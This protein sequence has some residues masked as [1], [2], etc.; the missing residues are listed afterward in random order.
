MELSLLLVILHMISSI[1]QSTLQ[2]ARRRLRGCKCTTAMKRLQ[3]REV[4]AL[5]AA[6]LVCCQIKRNVV[7]LPANSATAYGA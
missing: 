7:L 4:F 5:P 6:V 2:T 3:G 1:S